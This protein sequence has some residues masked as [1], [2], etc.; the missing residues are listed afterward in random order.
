MYS[1]SRELGVRRMEICRFSFCVRVWCVG[2][3]GVWRMKKHEIEV[4]V[5]SDVLLSSPPKENSGTFLL[6][7]YA[8]DSRVKIA[9]T[10]FIPNSVVH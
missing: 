5:V 6:I 8:I 10:L 4:W 7:R 9:T 1:V 3:L 2:E